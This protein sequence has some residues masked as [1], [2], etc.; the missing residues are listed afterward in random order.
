MRCLFNTAAKDVRR[1]RLY[2]KSLDALATSPY[3]RTVD[4]WLLAGAFQHICTHLHGFT[5]IPCLL[6]IQCML[7]RQVSQLCAKMN[8]LCC[9][10]PGEWGKSGS[11]CGWPMSRPCGR[12]LPAVIPLA[13][14]PELP[15]AWL[16]DCPASQRPLLHD[17]TQCMQ[18]LER[19]PAAWSVP[20]RLVQGVTCSGAALICISCGYLRKALSMQH[21]RWC[22]VQEPPQPTKAGKASKLG[23]P[24]MRPQ[25]S[26]SLHCS[27]DVF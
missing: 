12:L 19:G 11:S 23:Q 5:L 15:H 17:Q 20:P 9:P 24:A 7:I 16:Q 2:E 27:L 10:R 1:F 18:D 8:V 6:L 26:V 14:A 22:V 25:D 21:Q 4:R 3:A 13:G